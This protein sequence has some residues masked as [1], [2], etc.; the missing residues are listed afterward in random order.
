MSDDKHNRRIFP[1]KFFKKVEK[2]AEGE[3]VGEQYTLEEMKN[4][5]KSTGFAI[6]EAHNSFGFWGKIAWEFDRITDGKIALKILLMPL[7][8]L[9]AHF[10][11]WFPKL[12]GTAIC[13]IGQKPCLTRMALE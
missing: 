13:V 1:K 4:I 7:L 11:L 9:W 10:D 3:H 5:F 2:W 6:I 12:E 8:K